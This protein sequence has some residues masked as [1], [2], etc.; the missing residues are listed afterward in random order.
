METV[1]VTMLL[2]TGKGIF[3][4]SLA[5]IFLG[6]FGYPSYIKF[7]KQGTVFTVEEVEFDLENHKKPS[8]IEFDINDTP[9]KETNNQ[10]DD[11]LTEAKPIKLYKHKS[12][13][14]HDANRIQP[15]ADGSGKLKFPCDRCNYICS[16]K[17]SLKKHLDFIHEGLKVICEECDKV[18]AS[19][20]AMRRHKTIEH[21]GT[22][23]NCGMCD[24]NTTRR[25]ALKTHKLKQHSMWI[26]EIE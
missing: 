15:I 17:D 5:G 14:E 1:T 23:A 20:G 10:H 11:G 9:I 25:E 7:Q 19:L 2:L 26:N 3:V 6:Y 18:Y 16:T 24:Y 22:R 12:K 21:K 8:I 13:K 4:C